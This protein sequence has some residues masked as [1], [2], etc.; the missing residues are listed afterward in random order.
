MNRPSLELRALLRQRNVRILSV[1][2][3][4]LAVVMPLF[5]VMDYMTLEAKWGNDVRNQ[6]ALVDLL[7]GVTF[8]A[9]TLVV[10]FRSHLA[11]RTSALLWMIFG[12]S[13]VGSQCY[14]LYIAHPGKP[15]ILVTLILVPALLFHLRVLP[16]LL[17]LITPLGFAL[18]LVLSGR[19]PFI[20]LYPPII[21]VMVAG[22]IGILARDRVVR[23]SLALR[24]SNIKLSR[25]NRQVEL[26]LSAVQAL[27]E[28]QDGDY[29][30]TS[31]LIG[32]LSENLARCRNFEIETHVE[33]KKRF[34]FRH[35]E[36]EIGGD[37]CAAD[38]VE[39][40]GRSYAVILNGD[41]MGKSIQ[42]A[43]GS[44][45]LGTVF[46]AMIKRSQLSSRARNQ[47]PEQWLKECWLELSGVFTAFD[48]RML[49][50]ATFGLLDDEAGVLYYVNAEHPWAV[51]YRDGRAAFLESDSP[52]RKI[53][54]ELKQ[55]FHVQVFAFRPGDVVILGSDG[56]DDI[57]LGVGPDGHRR[58][59][60]SEDEF[61]RRVE[62]GGG[63]FPEIPQA[64]HRF[65]DLT[66]DLGLLS[67]RCREDPSFPLP[68]A[69]ADPGVAEAPSRA[70]ELVASGRAEDAVSL[71]EPLLLHNPRD[72]RLVLALYRVHRRRGNYAEAA[73]VAADFVTAFPEHGGFLYFAAVAG[74]AAASAAGDRTGIAYWAEFSERLRLRE[75]RHIKNLLNLADCLRLGG[76]SPRA[77]LIL[78][79]AAALSPEDPALIRLREKLERPSALR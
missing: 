5:A 65:G 50:S 19:Y 8:L 21:A 74:K 30:L 24:R 79:E 75:P 61:L 78:D 18:P 41:A 64:L 35:W 1:G 15:Y 13:L 76:D 10:R 60:E 59:N 7:L 37:L 4:I 52:L 62:E 66:D 47:Y 29:Y 51:L 53:G 72:D 69:A 63:R 57:S 16:G 36:A 73:R 70:G 39:L 25:S 54:I 11:R 31:L 38:Q 6:Y 27:K 23:Q 58:I 12:Y 49:V 22:V 46:K 43:G 68:S 40:F 77:R 2:A 48:G 34:R 20:D 71:L 3:P 42:G 32:P 45:V 28:Q 67:I 26:A 56:R 17:Y 14:L 44:L 55:D 33:Q 9:I